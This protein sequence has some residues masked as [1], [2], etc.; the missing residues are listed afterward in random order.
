M[1][2]HHQ[3][4]P[5]RKALERSVAQVCGTSRTRTLD[6]VLS[7]IAEAQ[8]AFN[9]SWGSE[10][11]SDCLDELHALQDEAREMIEA[12]LGVAWSRVSGASL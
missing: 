10:S 11:E 2:S 12:R 4:L 9:A 8:I 5:L 6:H 3:I 1:T 7:D